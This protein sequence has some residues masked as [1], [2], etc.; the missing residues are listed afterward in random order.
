MSVVWKGKCPKAISP[1]VL[2]DRSEI[3]DLG[4]TGDQ[5][6]ALRM[7]AH[8]ARD[9]TE[10]AERVL[11]SDVPCVSPPLSSARICVGPKEMNIAIMIAKLSTTNLILLTFVS[12]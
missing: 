9:P 7:S 1:S 12:F 8:H 4:V 6:S 2:L 10:G 5:G 11:V 3:L